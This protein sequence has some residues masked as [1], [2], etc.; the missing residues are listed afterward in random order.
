MR[1]REFP[2]ATLLKFRTPST[3]AAIL[4]YGAGWVGLRFLIVTD[5]PN[6]FSPWLELVLPFLM[7]AGL[8]ALAPLPWLWTGDARR[9]AP[10][11]RGLLQALPW[12]ALWLG[13][14]MLVMLGL[15]PSAGSTT[16]SDMR[17]RWFPLLPPMNPAW[18]IAMFNYP[19][20]LFLGWFMAGKERAEAAERELRALNDRTRAQV[21]Q[22]QLNPHVLFNVLGGLTELV[23][24]DPDAAEVALVELVAMYRALMR[25]GAAQRIPLR[26]ERELLQRYLGIEAIRLG[27]RLQVQW[28][29]PAWADV[30]EL[31]PL[32]LQPLVENAI[33]HGIA[34]APAG[35]R[36]R[37]GA[38]R[39]RETL[40]LRVA[41]TGCPL[42][43]GHRQG[44]GLGNLRERLALL[45]DLS[46]ALTLAQ[47]G[48]WAVVRLEL[49]WRWPE[50]A[51]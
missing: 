9:E 19:L 36:L 49:A 4:T 40:V 34:P 2:A 32:L 28:D 15:D 51:V 1:L 45:R 39:T 14:F 48:D 13:L 37:L 10:P 7:T 43:P 29:W 27:P 11:L 5:R 42:Q 30:L 31:P 38:S 22:A 18:G 46:P 50:G 3:W 17:W 21:L 6:L 33:R 35:G 20:A 41:N 16:H 47:D 24:E 8:V 23:H 12:N 25:H 44:T 26:E